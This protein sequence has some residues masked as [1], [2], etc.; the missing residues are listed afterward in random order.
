MCGI[1]GLITRS[2]VAEPAII[3]QLTDG[4]TH[5]GPD[6]GATWHEGSVNLGHRRLSI[7]D[8]SEEANQPFIDATGNYVLIFNGE[9][10]NYLEIRDK[11]KDKYQ[12]RTSSDTEV[13]L[14]AFIEYGER[15]VEYFNGMFALAI[16][17]KQEEELF[18]ARDR[19]GIKP[20]YYYLD[21]G[22]FLFG[23]EMT[24]MLNSGLVKKEIDT[25]S[26]STYLQYQTVPAPNTLIKNVKQLLPGEYAF[27][28]KGE[29]KKK[30]YWSLLDIKPQAITDLKEI[31][32]KIRSLLYESVRLRMVSDVPLGAFLSGGIDSTAV[33]ACM[34]EVGMNNINAFTVSFTDNQFDESHFA[35]LVAK[36]YGVNHNIIKIAP[37][38]ILANFENILT[39]FDVPSGDGINSYVVSE[40]TKKNGI[41]VALSG[42]GGDE[43]FCGYNS[44][45]NLPKILRYKA[46]WNAPGFLKTSVSNLL[47]LSKRKSLQKMKEMLS[48]EKGDF[49]H[50]YPFFRQTLTKKNLNALTTGLDFETTEVFKY[51]DANR[52]RLDQFGLLSKIS[53]GELFGYTQ[54]LL[55][56]DSDQVSMQHALEIRVPFFDHNLVEYAISLP[57]LPK[58]PSSTKRLLVESLDGLIPDEIVNR[59]KMGF[60]FPW[61]N[62]FRNELKDF[63]T[64]K[65]ERLAK[66]SFIDEKV[67]KT[68]WAQFQKTPKNLNWSILLS[69]ISLEIW[70]EK[71]QIEF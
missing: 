63:V 38:D 32:K 41:T 14:Y 36:K 51:L 17:N 23:S 70:L 24:P 3:Q 69:L 71:H 56:R 31:K 11:L 20:F 61:E 40:A 57:D 54:P 4:L 13:I 5:R 22:I 42:L 66:L 2:G 10:Y 49:Y 21:E 12:F 53:V 65:I 7:I 44:F 52:Q 45:V 15:C 18:I 55:L 19:M 39:A 1:T 16:W 47:G 27:Y 6:S 28:K 30:V 50:L 25:Q 58:T 29:L 48:G 34:K 26:I 35:S 59:P 33:V 46:L 43:L 67:I 64:A 68:Y 60:V 62:W 9:V 8:L 37:K